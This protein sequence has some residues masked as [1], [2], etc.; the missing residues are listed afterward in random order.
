MPLPFISSSKYT[1]IGKPGIIWIEVKEYSYYPYFWCSLGNNFFRKTS[2]GINIKLFKTIRL[3][4]TF[5][6]SFI[7]VSLLITAICLSLL[8]KNG[9][10]AFAQLF[11]FKIITLGLTVNFINKYK[12]KEFY[13]YLNSGVSKVMLWSVTLTLDFCFFISILNVFDWFNNS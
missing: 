4:W 5:Y 7:F 11:W 8:L 6:K 1:N 10:G 9:F 3:I 2:L 12:H 13:Y